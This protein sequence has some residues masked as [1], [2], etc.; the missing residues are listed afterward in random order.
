LITRPARHERD[1]TRSPILWA[2]LG[3]T[4][5]LMLGLGAALDPAVALAVA[6]GI[7]LGIACLLRPGLLLQVLVL[8]VFVEIVTLGGA[9][10]SRLVAPLALFVVAVTIASG[11][12]SLRF[13]APLAWV[14]GYTV[15]AFA[16]AI[17]SASL[18]GTAFQLGSLA[19]A[20]VYMLAFAVLLR[21][22][23][24]L[25]RTLYTLAF[26][27]L[28]IGLVALAASSFGEFRAQLEAGRA[29][30]GTGDP[31]F[32]AAYQVVAIPLVL[33]LSSTARRP[34]VRMFLYATVLVLIASVLTSLSRGGL[35]ALAAITFLTL[36]LPAQTLFRSR[37]QKVAVAVVVVICAAVAFNAV[38]GAFAPRLESMFSG[39]GSGRL[40]LWKGAWTS[41]QE[42]PL[43]GLGYGAFAPSSNDLILRTP[44]VSLQHIQLPTG[45]KEAHSAYIGTTADLGIPGLVLL[46]GVLASTVRALRRTAMRARET[47]DWFVMRV[48]SA[49]V[50][51]LAGWSVASLF[52]SSETSRPLWITIGI[53]LALPKL[54]RE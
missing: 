16:S 23:R 15:W 38:S 30:G 39:D 44:G 47:H 49:L 13:D 35:I 19:I 21:D 20:L 22:A 12:G 41:I 36:V 42:R 34:A 2:G 28:V 10:I 37:L 7:P 4:L 33:V 24:D 40:A 8:S 31:N 17:W 51:S 53:A 52:L 50:V 46:L 45:G 9:T 18:S 43:T 3:S 14:L 11:R 5:A 54:V 25:E 26:G 48:S 27:A 32:F 6:I 29:S 1:A